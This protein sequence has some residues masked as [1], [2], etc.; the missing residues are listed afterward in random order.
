MNGIIQGHPPVG[1]G[2]RLHLNENTGGCSPRVLAAI[3]GLDAEQIA[4]YPDYRAAV[5]ETAAFLRVAPER[6]ILTNGLDEGI[7]LICIAMLRTQGGVVPQVIV[8][9]PAFDAY[10]N[11]PEALGARAVKVP[12]GPGYAFP[13]DAVL[14]AITPETRLVILNSPNNPTGQLVPKEATR[15]IL[16][17]VPPG[18]CV[19]LDE[20]YWDFSGEQFLD[21]AAAWPQLLVGRTFSKAHGLAGMRIGCV[22]GDPA[23]LAPIRRVLPMFN[24][25]TVAV[26]A[27]RAALADPSFAPA[28]LEEV[29]ASRELLYEAFRHRGLEFWPSG[30]N[31]VLARIG[32]RASDVAA[33]LA[34]RG[35]HVRNRARDP[36]CPGCIRVTAGLVGHTRR[37]IA[38][39][40]E[41]L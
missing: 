3:R 22:I 41:V 40:E 16:R 12:P 5:V 7:L 21:E 17:A 8:P 10:V 36:W 19:L 30:A 20:A 11:W 6:L 14:R 29:R 34:A 28:Y 18:A 31:F 13:V 9:V 1:A 33:G 37:A 32:E 38:A 24:L 2:L 4:Q 35:V 23:L 25:N 39:L 27:L 15:A 26:T